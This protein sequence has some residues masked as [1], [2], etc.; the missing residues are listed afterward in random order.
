MIEALLALY[1]ICMIGV[2]AY[3][4]LQ[5][6]LTFIH[7]R[8]RRKRRDAPVESAPAE[9]PLITVQLP[10]YNERYVASRLLDCVGKL[11]YPPHRFDIQVL[12]DSTD[13]TPEIVA[14]KVAE[15]AARGLRVAHLRRADR[16]GYKAGAL[17]DALPRAAGEFIAI[18]DADFCPAADALRTAIPHFR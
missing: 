1:L 13:D 9:L 14:L 12:D 2:F 16:S 11:D 10:I 18:F 4:L 8:L 3:S 15:L 17:R 7:W 5:L 6:H